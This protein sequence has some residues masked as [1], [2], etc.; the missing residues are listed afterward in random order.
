MAISYREGI[1]PYKQAMSVKSDFI[2][3]RKEQV[4]ETV[5]NC[6]ENKCEIKK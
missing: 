4:K 6:V 1:V 5:G 2:L 3:D